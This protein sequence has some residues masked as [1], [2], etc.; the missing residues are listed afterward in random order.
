MDMRPS[1][2]SPIPVPRCVPVP[3]TVRIARTG[4]YGSCPVAVTEFDSAGNVHYS[5]KRHVLEKGELSWSITSH[6]A[7]KLRDLTEASGFF[8]EDPNLEDHEPDASTTIIKLIGKESTRRI[9][10]RG[11]GFRENPKSERQKLQFQAAELARAIED[12]AGTRVLMVSQR[13]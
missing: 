4:C 2:R 9:E 6:E 12:L 8:C 3:F 11:I 5:G 13:D 10:L 7:A 1:D